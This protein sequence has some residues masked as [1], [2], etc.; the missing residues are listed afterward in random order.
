M[1]AA[2]ASA[3]GLTYRMAVRGF[4]C[5]VL[6]MMSCS[7]RSASPKWVAALAVAYERWLGTSWET[8]G[9]VLGICRQAAHERFAAHARR[10][11]DQI[12]TSWLTGGATAAVARMLDRWVIDGLKH[13]HPLYEDRDDPARA[14]QVSIGL[15]P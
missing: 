14:R 6:P 3:P 12:A 8:V 15:H 2:M 5:P 13:G 7:G 1:T 10:L 9:E 11:D 4:L